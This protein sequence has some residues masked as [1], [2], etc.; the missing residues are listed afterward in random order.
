MQ[1]ET[2]CRNTRIRNPQSAIPTPMAGGPERPSDAVC[3][4]QAVTQVAE[5]GLEPTPQLTGK[6]TDGGI[7]DAESD[8]NEADM[9]RLA[10]ELRGRLAVEQCQRLAELLADE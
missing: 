5:E 1:E 7:C 8:V 2:A 10:G 9:R 3:H 6:T 4:P